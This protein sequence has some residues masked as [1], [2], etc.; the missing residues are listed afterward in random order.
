M[1]TI[2]PAKTDFP[3]TFTPSRGG[4]G[5]YDHP[6]VFLSD[7]P[8][9][10]LVVRLEL[11][12]GVEKATKGWERPHLTHIGGNDTIKVTQPSMNSKPPF[13]WWFL[14][15]QLWPHADRVVMGLPGNTNSFQPLNAW[16]VLQSP[17]ADEKRVIY[18]F[19]L[20]ASYI[21]WRQKIY[22]TVCSQTVRV[23]PPVS[24]GGDCSDCVSV[25]TAI[26]L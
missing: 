21:Y 4:G 9:K 5:T 19:I 11:G 25:F 17:T 12:T 14:N 26:A 6:T 8:H 24:E 1:H 18:T 7:G 2:S 3:F 22:K 23:N 10:P 16:R 15:L 13:S 20:I